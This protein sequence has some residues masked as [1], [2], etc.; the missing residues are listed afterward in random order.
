MKKLLI[1]ALLLLGAAVALP[2]VREK[3]PEKEELSE[4]TEDAAR[5]AGELSSQLGDKGEELFSR[6]KEYFASHESGEIAR[7]L[8]SIF[9]KTESLSDEELEEEIR[10]AAEGVSLKLSDEQVAWLR[11]LCRRYE[12]LDTEEL[13]WTAETWK[14]KLPSVESLGEAAEKLRDA[15]ELFRDVTREAGKLWDESEELRSD[16]KDMVRGFIGGETVPKLGED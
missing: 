4:L 1:V 6:M 15:G 11:G 8:R 2:A 7:H 14:D 3:A 13:R 16:L 9:Q 5:F 12:K 10:A